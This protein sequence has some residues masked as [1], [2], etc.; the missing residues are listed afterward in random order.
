[1]RFLVISGRSGSGKTSALHLL[2]DEG[3]TCIDNLPVNLLP[4]LMKQISSMRDAAKQKFAVG[5]DARNIDGDL[6]KLPELISG[7]PLPEN[8]VCE[9]V[10]LDTSREVLLK[11]FSETRRRHPLSDKSTS[12]NEAI[13]K[14]KAILTPIAAAA[15]ITIDTSHLNLHELRSTV[16][17]LVVGEETKGIAIT[18]KSFGFKHGIPVDADFIFDVRC[19]P[20]PY[21]SPALRAKSGLDKDVID[22]LDGEREVEEMYNDIL[23]FVLKWVPSFEKNNR[24][25]L[26][27]AIGCTGGFHRSVYLCERLAAKARENFSNVQTRHRQLSSNTESHA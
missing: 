12:L 13:A 18:F 21:W 19:L 25:Y 10:Y 3:F 9:I 11:R 26:T 24:S 7:T 8:A 1:M 2:E 22:F 27:V 15:D 16:K 4:A 14:E 23:A 17:S 20:N 6:S 5:I